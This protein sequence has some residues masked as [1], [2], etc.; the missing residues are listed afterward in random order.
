MKKILDEIWNFPIT[1]F[2]WVVLHLAIW[3]DVISTL[4]HINDI[5]EEDDKDDKL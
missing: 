4:D 5:E 2:A 1:F 3:L